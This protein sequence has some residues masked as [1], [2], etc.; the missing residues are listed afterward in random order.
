MADGFIAYLQHFVFVFG[1]MVLFFAPFMAVFY[2]RHRQAIREKKPHFNQFMELF[3]QS[4]PSNFLVLFWAMGEAIFWFIIP[5]FL[6]LLFIFMRIKRKK[7]LLLYDVLGTTAGTIIG[8]VFVIPHSILLQV[9][10]IFPNM[11]TQVQQW[12]EQSGIWALLYQP[13]SG[14]P[15]K[16]FIAEMHTYGLPIIAFILLAVTV[17]IARYAIAYYL[18]V[19]MYPAFH[20]FV[21]KHYSI[22]FIIG[23]ALF[24]FMLMR[25]STT[26]S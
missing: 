13:F 19:V 4:K 22:L 12:Y 14:V 6:L 9:P 16:V 17:R 3:F 21:Q 25:V 23:I 5:E 24:T 10:Y 26:Y 7:A 2:V 8:L 11:I 1:C 20:K 18:L 15:Y